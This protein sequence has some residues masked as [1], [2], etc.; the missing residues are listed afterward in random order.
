MLIERNFDTTKSQT[1][2]ISADVEINYG[3][4]CNKV[5]SLVSAPAFV[6]LT[7]TTISVAAALTTAADTIAP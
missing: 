5:Y 1:F 3:A 6:T 2:I 4:T 7:G